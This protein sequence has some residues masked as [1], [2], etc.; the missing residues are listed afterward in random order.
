[1]KFEADLLA[2]FG[3]S[4]TDF[5]QRLDEVRFYRNKFVAHLDEYNE[6]DIPTLDLLEK[7]LWF[8]HAH[9]VTHEVQPGDLAGIPTDTPQKLSQGYQQCLAE[10]L[11]VFQ[12]F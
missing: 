10:A 7:S 1:V 2:H 3:L 8:Y 6:I 9:I 12:R 11:Q 4:A 5:Q